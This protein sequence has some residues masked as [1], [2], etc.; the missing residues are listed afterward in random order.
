MAAITMELLWYDIS[1]S[2]LVTPYQ[3]LDTQVHYCVNH[4]A[5]T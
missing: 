5:S 3:S 2:W 1:L 4:V